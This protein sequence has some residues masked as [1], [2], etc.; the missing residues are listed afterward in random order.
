MLIKLIDV[1]LDALFPPRCL[2][3][4]EVVEPNV[5]LCKECAP[6]LSTDKSKRCTLCGSRFKECECDN[7]IY[8]FD[9]AISP[10]FNSGNPKKAYYDYKF[11]KIR[12]NARFFAERMAESVNTYYPDT[13]FDFITRVPKSKKGEFDHTKYLSQE[14][15]ECI[16]VKFVDALEPT[17]KNREIQRKLHKEDRFRNVDNAYRVI[18]PCKDKTVLL[19]DD[20]KTTGATLNECTRRL[21]FAGAKKVYC[22]SVL[23]GNRENSR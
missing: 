10:Y 4:E 13:K 7:Y 5:F 11:R 3:C 16:S 18:Y 8:I 22:I 20:I 21:K 1:F 14:L 19:L 17:G 15:S 6:K 23:S 2:L 9:G 12:R